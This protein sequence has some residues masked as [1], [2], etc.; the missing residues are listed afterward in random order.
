MDVQLF[1]VVVDVPAHKIHTSGSN[2]LH[3]GRQLPRYQCTGRTWAVGKVTFGEFVS[4]GRTCFSEVPEFHWMGAHSR[5]C[6]WDSRL[7]E[8]SC[9]LLAGMHSADNWH[10]MCENTAVFSHLGSSRH[11][12]HTAGACW[13]IP[14]ILGK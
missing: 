5:P 12:G 11:K 13:D 4:F 3:S 14:A 1:S 10:R 2:T 8:Y 6:I 7:R 9:H